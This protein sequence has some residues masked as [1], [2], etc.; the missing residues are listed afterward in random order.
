[1]L[2]FYGSIMTSRPPFCLALLLPSLLL[3]H[4]LSCQVRPSA[5]QELIDSLDCQPCHSCV[6][7]DRC[8]FKRQPKEAAE[9]NVGGAIPSD[10]AG[11]FHLRQAGAS[12]SKKVGWLVFFFFLRRGCLSRVIPAMLE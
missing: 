10:G 6:P 7:T 5:Q 1:M 11:Q 12:P 8:V 3:L 2:I 9:G 4:L